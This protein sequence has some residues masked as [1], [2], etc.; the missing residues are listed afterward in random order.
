MSIRSLWAEIDLS[1]I[2]HNVKEA[3]KAVGGRVEIMAVVKANAY[4]HGAARAAKASCEAGA[5]CLGV[6]LPEEGAYLRKSGIAKPI[7][8]L[9]EPAHTAVPMILD[10]NLTATVLSLGSALALSKEAV[11]RGRIAKVHVKVDTGMNRIGLSPDKTAS[12]IRELKELPGLEIEGVF[13]HFSEADNPESDY[14][15]YQLN[16]FKN[17]IEGLDE[18]GICPPVKHAANSA[19]M[20][21][22]PDSHF[23]MVRIGI[24]LYGLHPAEI[25]KGQVDLKPALS[26]KARLSFIKDIACGEGVSYGRVYKATCDTIIGT[27]PAGY[28]DGYSRL[29]SNKAQV[30]IGGRRYPA[31]GNICMDQFMVDLGP[32]STAKVDDEVVLIGRQGGEEI[33]ADEIAS[34]LGTINYEVVCMINDRVPRVYKE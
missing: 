11:K 24:S 10:Y 23:D 28:G 7:L 4:G 6:A 25:T 16:R 19:A 21:L 22:H 9:A 17:L 12:F 33:S 2:K 13:T 34:I 32:N 30:L 18:D 1:A 26:L 15:S 20:Y 3:R 29:L 31:V 14:T 8:I 5:S 27:V